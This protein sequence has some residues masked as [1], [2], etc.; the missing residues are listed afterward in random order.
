M[1]RATTPAGGGGASDVRTSSRSAANS[2][3]ARLIVAAS[4]GGAG[5]E[6]Y[7]CDY[8]G[9]PGGDAGAAGGTSSCDGFTSTG[10]GAG[11]QTAGGPGGTPYGAAG[12]LGQGGAGGGG[13]GGSGGGGL[14]GGGG[15]G[16]FVFVPLLTPYTAAGGGGGGSSLVPSGGTLEL[17]SAAPAVIISYSLPDTTPP[18]AHP[19]VSSGTLGTNGWYTS[20]VTVA[21]NWADNPGGSGL[22]STC[23]QTSTSSG[24][25]AN[26]TLT[27]SCKDTAGNTGSASYTVKVDKTPPTLS[28]SA[29]KA[30]GTPYVAGTWTNQPVTVHFACAD[31]L[32]GVATCPADQTLS[33][34][35]VSPNTQKRPAAD[36]SK[37]ANE[38]QVHW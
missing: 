25:G 12:S 33:A 15:G 24:E 3:S 23:T 21:W 7:H 10:G 14:F 28:A 13:V 11:S 30:D 5:F 22:S 1:A 8:I 31:A 17:T 32:S 4:G 37:A 19:T 36:G 26:I 9:M 29:T 18:T 6:G 27:A 20:D 38:G 34:P 2:L 16:K 35:G